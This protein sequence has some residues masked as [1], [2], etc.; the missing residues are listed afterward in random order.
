MLL[1]V[2]CSM[3]FCFSFEVLMKLNPIQ[4]NIKGG[5]KLRYF[6]SICF[7]YTVKA[8]LKDHIK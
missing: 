3:T 5:E 2:S 6:V 7:S 4:A 8:V 1:S